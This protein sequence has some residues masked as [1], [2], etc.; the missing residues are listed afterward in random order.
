MVERAVEEINR[1]FP[2]RKIDVNFGIGVVQPIK[3]VPHIFDR[4]HHECPRSDSLWW[5]AWGGCRPEIRRR[6]E[7]FLDEH[8]DRIA[9]ADVLI[10][11]LTARLLFFQSA[12]KRG[13]KNEQRKADWS[14]GV[15]E[16]LFALQEQDIGL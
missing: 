2:L 6:G 10:V 11:A 7:R 12:P 1:E 5:R 15:A 4:L 8:R 16:E 9:L 3:E 14:K 13:A